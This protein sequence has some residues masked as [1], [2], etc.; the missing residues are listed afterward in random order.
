MIWGSDRSVEGIRRLRARPDANDIVFPART[1]LLVISRGALENLDLR[2]VAR[3]IAQDVSVFEQKACASPHCLFLE[4]ADRQVVERIAEE[5]A[6]AMLA[7]LRRLPKVAPSEEEVAAILELRARYDILHR[8]WYSEG[9]EFTILADDL[10]Q[11]GPAVGNRTIYLRCVDDLE[12]VAELITAK[13]QTVGLIATPGE[14]GRLSERFGRAGVQRFAR[15]GAMTHFESPWD[16]VMIP[17]QMVR[18]TSRLRH[19]ATSG[20]PMTPLVGLPSAPQHT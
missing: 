13:V 17:Q 7:A 4:T 19:D 11:L 6:G 20:E 10:V 15:V 2:S 16:G 14:Y 3:R 18:W 9:T 8:A 1:S 5:L 12:R